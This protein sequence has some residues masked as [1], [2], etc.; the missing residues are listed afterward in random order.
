MKKKTLA[1]LLGTICVALILVAPAVMSACAKPAPAPA[2]AP[3]KIVLKAVSAWPRD[4]A[5]SADFKVLVDT[6][7]KKVA[8]QYPG[9]LEIDWIGGPE[10]ISSKDQGEAV[11][12]GIVDISHNAANYVESIVPLGAALMYHDPITTREEYKRGLTDY[13]NKKYQEGMNCV[14]WGTLGRKEPF[15]IFVNKNV[16]KPDFT[17]LT[18]RAPPGVLGDLIKAFGG[19]P[20][21]MPPTD[22]YT[23]LERGTVDGFMMPYCCIAD[24]GLHEVT[25]YVIQPGFYSITL[26]DYINLDTWN[27]LPKHLQDLLRDA[28]LEAGDTVWDI[29]LERE[30]RLTQKYRDEGMKEITFSPADTKRYVD[31]AYRVG[32]EGITKKYPQEVPQLKK[33][34]GLE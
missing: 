21:S 20:V 7:H 19:A 4:T 15:N 28:I 23:A 32:W 3:E 33:L 12:K 9:Q 31:T 1:V 30:R 29:S 27:K 10:T 5:L 8:E 24:F 11:M 34:Y 22:A 25:K 16:T 26:Q 18:F 13:W 14:F 2:P 17:G 6:V